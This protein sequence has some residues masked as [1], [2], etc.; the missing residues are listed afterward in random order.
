MSGGYKMYLR[1]ILPRF[2]GDARIRS[3]LCVS[4][5]T[6]RIADWAPTSPKIT[7]LDCPAFSPFGRAQG[8]EVERML[9]SFLPDVVFIPIARP[10]SYNR[11]P[12]VSMIQNMAPF[13]SWSWSGIRGKLKLA[14]QWRE[15]QLAVKKATRVIAISD[16]VR[17]SIVKKWDIPESK[18]DSIY[19][20]VSLPVGTPRKPKNIPLEWRSFLFTAGSIEPYRSLEDIIECAKYSRGIMGKPLNIV[21]AGNTGKDMIAYERHLR[22]MAETAGVSKDILWLG[23]IPQEEMQWCYKN[24]SSFIMTSRVEACPN[25]ALEAMINQALVISADCPP[26]PEFFGDYAKYYPAGNGILLAKAVH[27]YGA[28]SPAARED[29]MGRSVK[30]SGKFS[31]DVSSKQTVDVFEKAVKMFSKSGEN[32]PM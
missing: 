20:G 32:C 5:A 10:I 21:I 12:V 31:W 8:R 17:R 26:L 14:I 13:V 25:V 4:P 3:I 16:F 23:Y 29:L 27:Q 11:A 19:F 22:A 2:C 30:L 9:S 15:G 28:L 24:C 1:N 7:F 18:I 6:T